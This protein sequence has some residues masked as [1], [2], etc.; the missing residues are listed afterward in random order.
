MLTSCKSTRAGRGEESQVASTRGRTISLIV[1]ALASAIT[2]VAAPWDAPD[3]NPVAF[4]QAPKHAPI[5]LVE[6]G[7]AKGSIAVMGK[8]N[9]KAAAQLQAFIASATGVTLPLTTDR[10]DKPAIVLG[11]CP[12]A[13]AIGL[14]SSKLPPEGLAI[15]TAADAV[16][17][18]G[19]SMNRGADGLLWGIYE[20]AERYVG[21]R[22]YFPPATEDGPDI[23][24]SIPKLAGLSVPA[25][26]LEDAPVFRKRVIWPPVSNPWHGNGI[27]LGPLH[28]FL[29]HGSSW[30][31]DLRVHQ[32]YWERD[33]DLVANHP[34]VFQ[35]QKDGKRQHNVICY[36]HPKTLDMYLQGIQNFVDG[37]K[38]LYAPINGKAITV[39]PAD[40]ELACYCE[41]CRKLW[42]DQGGQYGG[43]SKVMAS[44]VDRLARQVLKRWPKQGFTIIFLPYLNYTQAP[45]GF[46]F[47]GNVEVQ[48]CG[49]PG[50]A[51][52]KEPAIRDAEQANI[53]KW[54]EI[55]GRRIQNWHYNVWPAHKTKAA[56]HYPHVV[57]DFYQRNLKTTVGTFINGD[58]NHWPRQHISLY[59]WL[60]VLWNPE[61]DVD[62]AVDVFCTRMFGP[63]AATMREMLG[64]QIDGWE[65]SRWP[66]GRFSPKGIYEA[67]FPPARS[68]KIKAL[69]AKA[70]K[71]VGA[72]RL[73][74]A[75]LDY[76]EPSLTD[77]FKEADMMSGK[78]FKSLQ[79]QKTGE[80]PT[81]DGKLDEA[82]WQRAPAVSF[83]KA[84][85]KSKGKPAKYPTT[86]QA[87]WTTKG[88]TFG[89]RL[90]EPT[91]NL[92]ETKNGGHDNGNMWWDDN[93]EIF[94]D[95]TGK[96]EGEFYQ[97]IVNPD[98]NYWDSKGKD[99]TWECPGFAAK[100]HI[101]K[102]F[103]SLEVFIPY[104]AIPEA[105]VPGSGTHTV[106][107]GNFTRHRVADRGL[108]STKPPQEGSVRE[109]QRM[110]T[111]G[112]KTS[113]NLAD[114]AELK[115]IE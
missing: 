59:C 10:I 107:T 17:I 47:P 87:L 111:T 104:A 25:V 45:D 100:S 68:E 37:K 112:S 85:G 105:K 18:V 34:E 9:A 32:P 39:S 84:T 36:S 35:Q 15:K 90:S 30:P 8:A 75:R 73:L 24:Q 57:K 115:F 50:M 64:L 110:N 97:F 5:V 21:V 114:F 91:P 89:F 65:K 6:K 83:V 55:S 71:E 77:F 12:Q 106:W 96:S 79:M 49:M 53:D 62:A 94:I 109:Y 28:T 23:G 46:K 72:D 29:R 99:T 44:F 82:V 2:A 74:M 38:P 7:A 13:K 41:Y 48:I 27:K 76:Y 31:I 11:D 78:G 1:A 61:F 33:A 43:A 88:V 52:Y 20:F 86:V 58:F 42:D 19:R 66:G 70:R 51:S 54:V 56:Y 113:D 67:S 95:V 102:D 80:A 22:W 40:V 3:L 101:G 69:F 60:K 108:K 16:F 98:G 63:A 14:D 103:W 93:V 4:R 92:L 81:L 26:W